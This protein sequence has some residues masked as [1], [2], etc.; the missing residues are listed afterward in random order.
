V[1]TLAKFVVVSISYAIVGGVA[2]LALLIVSLL[3]I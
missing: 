2:V 3:T 1:K